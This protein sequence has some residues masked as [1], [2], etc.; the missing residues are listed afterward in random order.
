M[1]A[2]SGSSK[3]SIS[4]RAVGFIATRSCARHQELAAHAAPLMKSSYR[5]CCQACSDRRRIDGRTSRYQLSTYTPPASLTDRAVEP[6]PP[7][8]AIDAELDHASARRAP[9]DLTEL[10]CLARTQS[11]LALQSP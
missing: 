9:R 5:D 2:T 6:L 10:L 3:V 11:L 1:V 8:C 4:S 7:A